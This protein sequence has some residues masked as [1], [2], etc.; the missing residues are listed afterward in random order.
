MHLGRSIIHMCI[1]FLINIITSP[2]MLSGVPLCNTK[3]H[4]KWYLLC[5]M[6]LKVSFCNA[7]LARLLM[8]SII[9]HCLAYKGAYEANI[10]HRDFSPGNVIIDTD[11]NG[12]LIDWDLS[13]PVTLSAETPRR[14][15][16]I[17]SNDYYLLSVMIKANPEN[18]PQ[19][20][21]S[22]CLLN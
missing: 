13:E 9:H 11:G 5:E 10:L 21:W 15:T 18:G 4:L 14:A 22:S 20:T 2:W 12:W 17:V 6:H 1:L 19:G 7:G 8:Q 16:K 3:A